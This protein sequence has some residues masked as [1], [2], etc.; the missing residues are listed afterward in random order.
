MIQTCPHV[1][2]R[3]ALDSNISLN[4]NSRILASVKHVSDQV[5]PNLLLYDLSNILF[6]SDSIVIYL[7]HHNIGS[8]R[9]WDDEHRV[10]AFLAQISEKVQGREH[11]TT[12]DCM[13]NLAEVLGSS[14]STRRWS[15]YF[16]NTKADRCKDMIFDWRITYF[17][18]YL[19]G[20]LGVIGVV[21]YEQPQILQ[22]GNGIKGVFLTLNGYW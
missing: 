20:R 10:Q 22:V 4:R 3:S 7:V 1:R 2:Q 15:E 5:Q 6:S 14:A 12:L 13:N 21:E 9:W 11:P 16:T 18:K 17:W 19:V 8:T